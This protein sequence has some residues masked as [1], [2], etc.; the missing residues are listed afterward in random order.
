MG[1]V[2]IGLFSLNVQGVEGAILLMLSHGFVV[3]ALFM[4]VLYMI[5]HIHLTNTMVV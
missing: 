5:E 3:S 2:T 1:F 4:L